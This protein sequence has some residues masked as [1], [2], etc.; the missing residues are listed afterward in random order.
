M[1]K[2]I[3]CFLLSVFFLQ[4]CQDKGILYEQNQD[5]KEAKW[6][7]E[8]DINFE[9]EV[10]DTTKQY[11]IYYHIRN[12]LSYPYYN[13]YVTYYLHYPD[14]K[15]VDSLLQDIVLFHPNTGEPFGEGTGGIREHQSIALPK[16]RFSQKG[17][18][19]YRFKQYM[20]D[21]PLKG[22]ISM[23]LRIQEVQNEVKK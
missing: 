20:R 3:Y 1:K 5:I 22:I 9:F 4:A 16:F 18:Y 7:V 8:K 12:E 17:K 10:K 14:G 2:L 11:D 13:M 19:K 6:K 15:K 21:N 23:G